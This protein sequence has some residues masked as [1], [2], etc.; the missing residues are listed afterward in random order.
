MAISCEGTS[1][2]MLENDSGTPRDPSFRS[3][4]KEVEEVE[5]VEGSVKKSS[6]EAKQDGAAS[7]LKEEY[8]TGPRLAFVVLALV[9]SIFLV[10]LDMSIDG[11]SHTASGIHNLPLILTITIATISSSAFI[12]MTGIAA[13]IIPVGAAIVTVAA[14]LLYTLDIGSSSSKWI[15]SQVLG[16]LG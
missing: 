14:G 6:N 15:G 11:T 1:Q 10:S 12:S 13:P 16:G 8:L 3:E 4:V 2:E 7:L 5:E 9:L